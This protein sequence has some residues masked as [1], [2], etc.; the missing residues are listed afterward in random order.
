MDFHQPL[1]PSPV[2]EG[3]YHLVRSEVPKVEEDRFFH[4]DIEAIYRQVHEGEIV[5]LVEMSIG[6]I[7]F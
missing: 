4:P 1:K 7:E 2:T 3:V 5:K 6:E